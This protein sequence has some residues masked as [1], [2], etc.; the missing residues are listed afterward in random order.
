[1]ARTK[2][3][4][5]AASPEAAA[6]SEKAYAEQQSRLQDQ[7]DTALDMATENAIDSEQNDTG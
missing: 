1:M 5:E 3:T 6:E 7:Q 2:Y 4:R